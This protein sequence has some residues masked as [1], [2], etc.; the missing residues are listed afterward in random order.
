MEH[1]PNRK[2]AFSTAL[3]LLM[4]NIE[5]LQTSITESEIPAILITSLPSVRWLT[6]F[7]GSF[8]AA[9]VTQDKVLFLTDSRYTLQA[10]EQCPDIETKSFRNPKKFSEFLKEEVGSFGLTQLAFDKNHATVATHEEW[11]EVL[12]GVELIA[13]CD[14]IENLRKQKTDAEISLMRKACELADQAIELLLGKCKPG[15]KEIELFWIFEDFL[16]TVGATSA[17]APIM[18]SG[19]R[20]ARP[21]GE[22]SERALEAG[23]FITFDLGVCIDGYNS[24]ITRTVVLGP[25]S[26]RQKEIYNHLL[27]TQIACIEAMKPGV[28]GRDVDALARTMLDEKDLGQYF[29]HGLGH[30][31]GALVHDSGRLSPTTDETIQ[32]GQIWTIEPGVY[33]EG[34]GGMRI[35]DDILITESGCEVLTCFPK[36]LIELPL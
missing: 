34:F 28:N 2:I 6:G 18:I 19:P 25:A 24:D 32:A 33:I 23:D 3:E 29:G 11:S 7:T 5:R 9:L 10:Q 16:R 1:Q 26:D 30:G 17:F 31:L 13:E 20:T 8:G 27:K 15:V 14:P 12:E 36:T 21:H 35:E 4:S 22:P